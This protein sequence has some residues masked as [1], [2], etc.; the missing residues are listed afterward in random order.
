[1]PRQ[2][3]GYLGFERGRTQRLQVGNLIEP[4]DGG[5]RIL[6]QVGDVPGA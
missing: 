4:G 5:G 2:Q 1:M 3:R 6:Q